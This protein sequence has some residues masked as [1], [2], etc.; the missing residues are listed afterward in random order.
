MTLLDRIISVFGSLKLVLA[1]Y[2]WFR[3][4]IFQFS[5]ALVHWLTKCSCYN[6]L[7]IPPYDGAHTSGCSFGFCVLVNLGSIIRGDIKI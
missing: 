2:F 4:A 7:K 1:S 3:S 6:C 5:R